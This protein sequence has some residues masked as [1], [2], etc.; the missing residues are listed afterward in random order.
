MRKPSAR[1]LLSANFPFHFNNLSGHSQSVSGVRLLAAVLSGLLLLAL[2][3]CGSASSNNNPP[4][5]TAPTIASFAPA[6][7][8]PGTIV[9]IA[10]AHLTGATTVKFN[11]TAAASFTVDSDTQI[12]ATVANGTNTG[13]ISVVTA[14][15]T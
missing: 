14:G 2:A 5:P 10:G 1:A 3:G 13:K 12:T 4:P 11:G 8:N 15:G 7:G 6:S 9:V